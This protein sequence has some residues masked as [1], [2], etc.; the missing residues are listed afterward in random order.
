MDCG[1]RFIQCAPRSHNPFLEKVKCFLH[2]LPFIS[3]TH[4][5]HELKLILQNPMRLE[6]KTHEE[7]FNLGTNK[8]AKKRSGG[9]VLGV[10]CKLSNTPPVDP[11]KE[12][13]KL[14]DFRGEMC[15]K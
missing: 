1:D 9:T 12:E 14:L 10:P 5:L 11:C 7:H 3:T 15:R 6:M 13:S 2:K 8:A 4:H